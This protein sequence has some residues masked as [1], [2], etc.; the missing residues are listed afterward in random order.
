M[1]V[2]QHQIVRAVEDAGAGRPGFFGTVSFH[3]RNGEL[4]LI[5]REETTMITPGTNQEK[6]SNVITF[7]DHRG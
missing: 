4:T 3:F 5:R 2:I 7:P 6:N 1:T